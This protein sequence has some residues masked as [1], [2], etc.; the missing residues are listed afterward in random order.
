MANKAAPADNLCL[1]GQRYLGSILR[2]Q[3]AKMGRKRE[4]QILIRLSEKEYAHLN[5]Q[6]DLAQL[7]INQFVRNLIM[8]VKMKPRPKKEWA[9]ILRQ[10]SAI[11]NNLNQIVYRAELHGL[12]DEPTLLGVQEEFE[13][14]KQKMEEF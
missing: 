12:T 7:N 2:P 4:K 3:E 1:C 6:A 11:G 9:E 13:K 14:L 8:S 5:E 10:M